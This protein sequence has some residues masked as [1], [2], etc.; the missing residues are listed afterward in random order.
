MNSLPQWMKDFNSKKLADKYYAQD[1]NTIY[2]LNT[3]TQSA[4]G[5]KSYD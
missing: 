2:P 1:W 5:G 4:E 3:Y